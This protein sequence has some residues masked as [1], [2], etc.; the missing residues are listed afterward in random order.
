MVFERTTNLAD[1][2]KVCSQGG[3]LRKEVLETIVPRLAAWICS[4]QRHQIQIVAAV[5]E[6]N[7]LHRYWLQ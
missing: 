6:E 7:I 1:K 5:T 4:L 3:D 2:E